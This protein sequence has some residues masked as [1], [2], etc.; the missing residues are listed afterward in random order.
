VNRDHPCSEVAE[1][2][3]VGEL[4]IPLWRIGL[5]SVLRHPEE[6]MNNEQG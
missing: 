3:E 1:V 4:R 6:G 5:K 2:A